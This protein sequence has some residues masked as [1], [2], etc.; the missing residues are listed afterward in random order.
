MKTHTRLIISFIVL[1]L[2]AILFLVPTSTRAALAHNRWS[3]VASEAA[4]NGVQAPEL[5]D[6]P[7]PNAYQWLARLSLQDENP[8][9]ALGWLSQECNQDDVFVTDARA[10]ALYHSGEFTEAISLWQGLGYSE[11]LAQIARWLRD[12]G[13]AQLAL[14]A[15]RAAYQVDPEAGTTAY[16]RELRRVEQFAEAEALLWGSLADFPDANQRPTWWRTLG[17]LYQQQEKWVAAEN[18]FRNGLF[19]DDQDQ[20][21]WVRLGWLVYD[22]S[23][24]T[25]AAIDLFM[26]AIRVGPEYHHGYSAMGQLMV[27]EGQP[28]QALDWYR[29]AS[30][31]SPNSLGNLLRYANL[32]R[33]LDQFELAI[34]K[35]QNAVEGWPDSWRAYFELSWAYWGNHQ[36]DQAIRAIESAIDLNPDEI[37]VFLRA[38]LIYEETGQIENALAAYQQVLR[39]NPDHS[40]ALAAVER[41]TG[42][43]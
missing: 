34:I 16:A 3:L 4:F 22:E 11:R 7:H 6:H 39:L 41:L 43:E 29:Q 30:E 36:T 26:Q 35:Y 19:E 37:R 20:L 25:A 24:D 1:S 32:L 17:E 2:S 42:G 21:A 31:T 38:G 28:Q 13:E 15:L 23:G 40:T 10:W 33:D 5:P 18:A 9:A 27:R 8:A 14:L 12:D